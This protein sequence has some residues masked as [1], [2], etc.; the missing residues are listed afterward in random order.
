M[1]RTEALKVV[2]AHAAAGDIKAAT[3]VFIENRMSRAAYDQAVEAG[4]QLGAMIAARDAV[5]P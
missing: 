4:R 2:K 3:R 1:T 5:K